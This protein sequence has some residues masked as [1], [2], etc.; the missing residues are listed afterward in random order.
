MLGERF[1]I[2][3]DN[4]L[5]FLL[6]TAT[7]I[8]ARIKLQE[9][10]KTVKKGGLWYEEALPTETILYGL[11][12]ATPPRQ[13]GLNEPGIFAVVKS[14]IRPVVQLGGKATVG[15]GLCRVLLQDSQPQAQPNQNASTATAPSPTPTTASPQTTTPASTAKQ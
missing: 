13:N 6:D 1:C 3:S 4:V 11:V 8:T 10:T 15:R 9:D 2:V 5:S 14:S 12:L 7:E